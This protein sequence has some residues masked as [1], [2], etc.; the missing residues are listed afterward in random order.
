MSFATLQTSINK[1]IA[2]GFS[3]KGQRSFAYGAS[4]NLQ[5]FFMHVF[6]KPNI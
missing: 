1:A 6:P 4:K 3:I 2:Q 5:Q